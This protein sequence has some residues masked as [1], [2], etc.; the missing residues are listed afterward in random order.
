M[1]LGPQATQR[2]TSQLQSLVR[3]FRPFTPDFDPFSRQVDAVLY[4]DVEGA[5]EFG[6]GL[7]VRAAISNVTDQDPPFVNGESA[8]NTDA[9]TYRLLGRTY[10][11]ELRYE[12]P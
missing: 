3:P 1:D 8:G 4:H 6:T 5:Y 12:S 7:A 10:F 9:G 11:L 2:S